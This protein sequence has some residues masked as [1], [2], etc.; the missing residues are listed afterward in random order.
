MSTFV[1]TLYQESEFGVVTELNAAGTSLE[2]PYVYDSAARDLRSMA[3]EGLVEIIDQVQ[4]H[5]SSIPL[6]KRITFARLR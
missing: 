5:G 2:N 1:R 4:D 6:I 3:E